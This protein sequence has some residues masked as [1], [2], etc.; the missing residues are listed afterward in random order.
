MEGISLKE[1]KEYW[2]LED[3]YT[4]NAIL[5][6]RADYKEAYRNYIDDKYKDKD[7]DR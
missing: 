2:S 5:D 7:K 4:A 3:V 1:I 6:M